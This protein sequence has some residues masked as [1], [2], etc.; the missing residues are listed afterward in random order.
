MQEGLEGGKRKGKLYNYTTISKTR[1]ITKNKKQQE[2][3]LSEMLYI[4]KI[5]V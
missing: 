1:E 5:Y 4:S 2:H 3:H